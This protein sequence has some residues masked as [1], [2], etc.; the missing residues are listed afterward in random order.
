[1]IVKIEEKE[2]NVR[3]KHARGKTTLCSITS[4]KKEWL[5]VAS[6][7]PKDQ[8]D[9]AKGRKIALARALQIAKLSKEQKKEF[10]ETYRNWGKKRF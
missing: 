1:M 10:W 7:H 8:F 4:D 3:F 6:V 5:S 9:K 2:Y